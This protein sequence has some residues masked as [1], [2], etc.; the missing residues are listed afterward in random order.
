MLWTEI[1]GKMFRAL[2]TWV[3][4]GLKTAVSIDSHT[5]V[6]LKQKKLSTP[7]SVSHIKEMDGICH[8][9]SSN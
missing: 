1:A 5:I 6:N 8:N 3:K 9:S 2:S 7:N 4:R